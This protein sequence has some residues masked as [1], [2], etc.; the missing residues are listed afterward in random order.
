MRNNPRDS[1]NCS[2]NFG[3]TKLFENNLVFFIAALVNLGVLTCSSESATRI[4]GRLLWYYDPAQTNHPTRITYFGLNQQ[5]CRWECELE[6]DSEGLPGQRVY[7]FDGT[8]L[9]FLDKSGEKQLSPGSGDDTNSL[10]W[11]ATLEDHK[12]GLIAMPAK[13]ISQTIPRAD[14][15]DVS[16]VWIAFLASCQYGNTTNSTFPSESISY[17]RRGIVGPLNARLDWEPV[18]RGALR[19]FELYT[20]SASSVI[21]PTIF[22]YKAEQLSETDG[23]HVPVKFAFFWHR[24]HQSTNKFAMIVKGV[25]DKHEIIPGLVSGLP[26]INKKYRVDDY[27]A[28]SINGITNSI[29]SYTTLSEWW[30]PN[31]KR[32]KDAASGTI[33]PVGVI[34]FKYFGLVMFGALGAVYGIGTYIKKKVNRQ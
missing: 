22:S 8:S 19:Y 5:D 23:N 13:V 17:L 21:N 20:N 10:R 31:E 28:S 26:K 6:T 16:L 33:E 29:V 15:Y 9:Y 25:V 3:L 30:Q 18:Q 14:P 7:G 12:R 2:T 34:N 27:R 24:G 4:T 32:F 11:A 1:G